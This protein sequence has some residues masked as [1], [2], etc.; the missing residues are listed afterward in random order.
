MKYRKGRQAGYK[1]ME[2]REEK[3]WL[4]NALNQPIEQGCETGVY[5]N[6]R[7]ETFEGLTHRLHF[8]WWKATLL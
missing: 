8:S 1:K 4:L 6:M 7:R 2:L 5:F 3:Y